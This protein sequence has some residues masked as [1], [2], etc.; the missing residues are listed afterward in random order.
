MTLKLHQNSLINT[1]LLL[2]LIF[3]SNWIDA[4]CCELFLRQD[5]LIKN[6][7]VETRE[8]YLAEINDNQLSNHSNLAYFI[9]FN[10]LGNTT[11]FHSLDTTGTYPVQ[12]HKYSW[13]NKLLEIS[14]SFRNA[15][16]KNYTIKNE[17]NYKGERVCERNIQNNKT[18]FK[19]DFSYDKKGKLKEKVIH[20]LTKPGYK[21]K[22]QKYFYNKEN[23]LIRT[24]ASGFKYIANEMIYD[25]NGNRTH[26][27]RIDRNGNQIPYIEKEYNAQN[28]LIK[29]TN[30]GPYLLLY[31]RRKKDKEEVMT[32]TYTYFENGLLA[33]EKVLIN[34]D[35]LHFWEYE[36]VFFDEK[37]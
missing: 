9:S 24:T 37:N 8:A 11:T 23:Q 29:A 21:A 1:T 33:T 27:Y 7:G 19:T 32:I 26:T 2:L 31:K 20:N 25:E 17:F 5:S 4:Q 10:E 3:Q 36:Y 12:K 6:L 22:K 16:E 18:M 13:D 30:Y 14:T 15:P 28:Q 35:L 34:G